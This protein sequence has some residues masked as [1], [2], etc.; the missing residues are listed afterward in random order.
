MT[1]TAPS[2][3]VLAKAA[4]ESKPAKR[5]SGYS[6]IFSCFRRVLFRG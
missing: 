5:A 6:S 2:P 3:A 4:K 1:D